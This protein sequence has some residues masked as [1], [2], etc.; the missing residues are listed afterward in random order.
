[1]AS[2]DIVGILNADDKYADTDVLETVAGVFSDQG[3][4]AC[5]GDLVYVDKYDTS[6]VV[7]YWASQPCAD[8]LLYRGWMP[9]HPTFFVRR[10]AYERYGVFRTDLGSA[11]DYELTLRFLLRFRIKAVYKP[12]LMVVMRT[13][14][15][16]N[17][18][19][20]NRIRV[21]SLAKEAWRVNDLKP[22][23]WTMLF[24][25]LDRLIQYFQSPR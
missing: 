8:R 7:R 1:M 13:G 17:A 15:A 4:D 10:S 5:Y 14:G 25:V 2:G 3:V 24:R 12:K 22:K 18:S 20:M 6:R 11:A 9:P 16:S 19:I 23:Q 21:H